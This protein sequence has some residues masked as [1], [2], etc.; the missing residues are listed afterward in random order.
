MRQVHVEVLLGLLYSGIPSR[1]EITDIPTEVAVG[2]TT[3]FN[4]TLYGIIYR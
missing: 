3:Y 2:D 1:T 4:V